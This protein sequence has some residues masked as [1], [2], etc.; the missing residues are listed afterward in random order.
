MLIRVSGNLNRAPL[1][2]VVIDLVDFHPNLSVVRDHVMAVKS[3]LA[4]MATACG[5]GIL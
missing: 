2:S 5:F 4:P 1:C 3:S